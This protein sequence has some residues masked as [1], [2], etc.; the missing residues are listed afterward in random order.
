MNVYI[1]EINGVTLTGPEKKMQIDIR[2]I[3]LKCENMTVTHSVQRSTPNNENACTIKSP[4]TNRQPLM[5][6]V[7]TLS[8]TP[9]IKGK[10][11]VDQ[12]NVPACNTGTTNITPSSLQTYS[13]ALQINVSDNMTS[14][15][16]STLT[17]LKAPDTINNV[18]IDT[19]AVASTRNVQTINVQGYNDMNPHHY[20]GRNHQHR[21]NQSIRNSN[22]IDCLNISQDIGTHQHPDHKSQSQI[23]R[24]YQPAQVDR[25]RS[26]QPLADSEFDQNEPYFGSHHEDA[27]HN[28]QKDTDEP[29]FQS[30]RSRR[31]RRYYVGGIATY[32]NRAGIIEFLKSKHV[33]PASIKLIDTKRGSLAAKLT[34]YQSDCDI[35]EN[36]HF[37]PRRVYC[38][39]WYSEA[40]WKSKLNENQ[41]TNDD[42][43]QVD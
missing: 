7:I 12:T 27:Y 33:E 3:K 28:Q 29:V 20:I 17:K 37:W 19:N 4:S 32:S 14:A 40:S 36:R 42:R 35:I 22:L 43:Q 1:Y 30:V 31:T 39:R 5:D 11:N 16:G 10:Q 23:E 13:E 25:E 2:D 6:D 26:N 38:R 34:I 8:S 15:S 21:D 18:Q 41:D 9:L 24:H